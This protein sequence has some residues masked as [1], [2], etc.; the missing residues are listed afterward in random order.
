MSAPGD[1][2]GVGGE[3]SGVGSTRLRV[4]Q[5][6]G[7]IGSSPRRWVAAA[8]AGAVVVVLAFVV[9]IAANGGGDQKSVDCDRF[10]VT[11]ELWAKAGYDRRIQLQRGLLDCR[12]LDGQPD[13]EVVATLGPPDRNGPSELDYF[14]PFGRGSTDRQVWRIHLD[15]GHRVKS[16][17]T[18]SP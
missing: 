8:A 15:A 10:R 18:D 11:P 7:V 1:G 2:A 17:T 5:A 9:L 3:V 4:W 14:L 12:V 16:S 6:G 13:T